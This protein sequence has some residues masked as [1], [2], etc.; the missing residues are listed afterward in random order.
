MSIK[1]LPC[2]ANYKN[3]SFRISHITLSWATFT[4]MK[5]DVEVHLLAEN[6]KHDTQRNWKMFSFNYSIIFF[7]VL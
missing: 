7:T 5:I 3:T 6:N 2:K 4:L 1:K